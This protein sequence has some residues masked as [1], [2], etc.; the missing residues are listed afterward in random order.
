MDLSLP[1]LLNLLRSATGP[2]DVFGELGGDQ[3]AGLKR[4][5]RELVAIAH[6]DR[7][8]GSM[9]AANEACKALQEWHAVAQRQ[10]VQGVYGL[11]PRISA[12][13]KL[14]QYLGYAPPIQGDLC[15]LFPAEAGGN[16]VLLKIARQ[17]RNNDLLQAEAQ[18]LRKI[19]RALDGQ[20]TRAHFPTLVEHFLLRTAAGDQRH[21]NVLH[22]ES[23]Y[24]SLAEILDAYPGG[25]PAADAAW[26]F[27]RI[28]TA[29]GI[30]HSLGI[31][32]GAVVPAHVLVRPDDHN[33]ML[34]DWCYSVPIGQPIKAISPPYAAD[35]PPE[36][37]AKLPATPATD[38]YMAARCMARLLGG[39][40]STLELPTSVPRAIRTLLSACL[41]PAAQ[42]R[43]DDAWHVFDDFHEILG[44]LYGPPQFRPFHMPSDKV[45]R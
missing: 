25:L 9:D 10:I 11:A 14:H 38:L 13:T 18:A 19:S 34:I 6:P 5:Y 31:V 44:R 35:Y 43:A 4:R 21:T 42:R 23:G 32:H 3:Q 36:V 20:L 22:A 33:G 45:T 29:L 17:A 27:N 30:A 24:V 39:H 7:N 37:R 40:P 15:E 28:L 26:M 12:S 8:Q 41:L 1:K 2:A 16:P